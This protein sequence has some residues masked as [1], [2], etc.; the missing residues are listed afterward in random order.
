MYIS[1]EEKQ[2]IDSL[3]CERL[4]ANEENLRK[5]DGFYNRMNDSLATVLKNEA[6]AD[7]ESGKMAYYVVKLKDGD[8]LMFF[9]LKTGLLYDQHIDEKSIKMFKKLNDFV[10]YAISQPDMTEEQAK[11][12][13]D[14]LEKIR[15]HK[16]ISKADLER[17]PK[18]NN[19]LFEELEAELNANITHVGRTYSGV[20]LV[21]FCKNDECEDVVERLGLTRRIGEVV[22]WK[23]LVPIIL[24]A[25][26]L[27]GIEY[28]FLF[29]ADVTKT[30]NLVKY[31][32]SSMKFKQD[33]E[34]ATVKPVY[35]FSCKFMYQPID[36]IEDAMNA[37]WDNYMTDDEV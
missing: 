7:D 13:A 33:D 11:A 25:R 27:I 9:S 28:L 16:G 26:K 1:T 24:E 21:H 31:Y 3:T 29:A 19:D 20:E 8:I 15:T 30:H 12:L 34:R 18:K 17:L 35:D 6:F 2:V 4:S 10:Q 22:F 37:F 14:L 23:F 5:V 32:N 36:G